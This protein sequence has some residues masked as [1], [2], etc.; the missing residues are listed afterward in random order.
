MANPIKQRPLEPI[1]AQL[2]G[3]GV[4]PDSPLGILIRDLATR[5]DKTQNNNGELLAVANISGRTEQIG[6]TVSGLSNTG[7]INAATKVVGRTEGLGT[8]VGNL[9]ATGKLT[10]T[11]AIAA[12]G[13]GSP[14][15]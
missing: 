11:D 14:L 8:T 9:D 5:S 15:T 13:T 1:F 6:T 10:S 4:T 2:Q 7:D 3:M 12:D